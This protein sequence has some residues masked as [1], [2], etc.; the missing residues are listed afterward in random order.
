[1][2]ITSSEESRAGHNHSVNYM[3]LVVM[4]AL[5]SFIR[6][7]SSEAASK[8]VF[9]RASAKEMEVMTRRASREGWSIG[10]YDFRCAYAFNPKGCYMCEVDGQVVS[11]IIATT[12][13]NH[14]S[15]IGGLIVTEEYRNRGFGKRTMDKY[16][17]LL[18][19]MLLIKALLH[20]VVMLFQR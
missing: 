1:M 4:T 18:F 11:H 6:T 3:S 8:F 15:H 13:P 17:Y 20:L 9:R 10:P 14:Y 2:N 19:W 5:K 12:Y 7:F 16:A